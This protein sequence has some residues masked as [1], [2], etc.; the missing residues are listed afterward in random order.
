M[1]ALPAESTARQSE[2]VGQEMPFRKLPESEPVRVQALAPPVGL[3]EK[4]TR[5]SPSIAV[6]SD[7]EAHDTPLSE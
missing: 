6:H 1:R 2:V 5:E 4:R 7:A 3:L